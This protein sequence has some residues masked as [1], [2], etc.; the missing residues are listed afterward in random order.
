MG[1]DLDAV[2]KQALP[3]NRLYRT[4]CVEVDSGK[5]HETNTHATY[6]AAHLQT[7][8]FDSLYNYPD[9]DYWVE[10]SLDGG[11]TWHTYNADEFILGAPAWTIEGL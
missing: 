4:V 10:R 11:K 1:Q 7:L 2:R 9:D 8:E 3:P 5:V 6:K